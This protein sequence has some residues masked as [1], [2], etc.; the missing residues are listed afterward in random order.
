[1]TFKENKFDFNYPPGEWI[2]LE[3]LHLDFEDIFKGYFLNVDHETTPDDCADLSS[4][5]ISTGIG[6]HT[7]LVNP[8]L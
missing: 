7:H 4:R 5:I 8:P 3:K 1:M 2:T 6:R